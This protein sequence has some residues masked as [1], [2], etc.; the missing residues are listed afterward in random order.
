[1]IAE[2]EEEAAVAE[3]AA[4]AVEET[5]EEPIKIPV[6]EFVPTEQ[7]GVY[8]TAK[9]IAEAAS[10]V[11]RQLRILEAF[12]VRNELKKGY[13][14]QVRQKTRR[15]NVD[16][17]LIAVFTVLTERKVEPSPVLC[18]PVKRR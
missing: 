5:V 8:R 3:S 1:M 9:E 4:I 13:R 18:R 2:Q 6:P 11:D 10:E 15:A 17:E 14:P 16:G 7:E 12:V